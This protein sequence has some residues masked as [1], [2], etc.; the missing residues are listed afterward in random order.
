[1]LLWTWLC[2]YLFKSLLSA[3]LRIYPKVGLPGHMAVLLSSLRTLR[4]AFRSGY[5]SLHGGVL[6]CFE[7]AP[8]ARGGAGHALEKSCQD[9]APQRLSPYRSPLLC[10]A[11]W[12]RT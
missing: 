1:M 8:Q 9:R 3:F 12:E 11:N 7:D 4:N 2:T 10:H 6:A 5:G